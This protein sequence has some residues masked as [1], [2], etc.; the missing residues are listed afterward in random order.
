M[1]TKNPLESKAILAAIVGLL[2]YY[3]VNFTNIDITESELLEL[4][5]HILVIGSF[6]MTMYGRYFAD[7][8]ISFFNNDD[9]IKVDVSNLDDVNKN[10]LKGILTG[11]RK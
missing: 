1:E 2:S 6:L 5:S 4:G 8:K 9:V 11:E 7:K 3:F 10:A